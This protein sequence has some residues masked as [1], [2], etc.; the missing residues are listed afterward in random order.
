MRYVLTLALLFAFIASIV[1]AKSDRVRKGTDDAGIKAL[2]GAAIM[3]GRLLPKGNY[4]F[5][6][7]GGDTLRLNGLPYWPLRG[8]VSPSK[9]LPP[10]LVKQIKEHAKGRHEFND[11][12]WKTVFRMHENGSSYEECLDAFRVLSETEGI[13]PALESA[14][15]VAHV[16]KL[17]PSMSRESIIIINLS[18]RGD[19]DVNT[20]IEHIKF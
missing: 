17:A 14:H 19:K 1:G 5:S 13:I 3:Y 9:L 6:N 18:G 8:R 2:E 15:A 16:M 12:T 20:A 4:E 11:A 10:E 7:V